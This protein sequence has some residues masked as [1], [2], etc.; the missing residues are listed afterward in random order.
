MAHSLQF[1][2]EYDSVIKLERSRCCQYAVCRLQGTCH[3]LLQQQQ[4]VS[5]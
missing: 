4:R 2:C 5:K 3:N 1:K